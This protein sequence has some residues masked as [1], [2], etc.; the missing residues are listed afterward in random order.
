VACPSGRA[1]I[2]LPLG[3]GRICIEGLATAGDL[4]RGKRLMIPPTMHGHGAAPDRLS[5]IGDVDRKRASR[6]R[7]PMGRA[8]QR[9]DYT[10]QPP[11]TDPAPVENQVRRK[12]GR[13]EA[14]AQMMD[15]KGR[16][17]VRRG[18]ARRPPDSPRRIGQPSAK[19][20]PLEGQELW[21]PFDQDGVP[22]PRP[23]RTLPKSCASAAP[24]QRWRG[25]TLPLTPQR[26]ASGERGKL[27]RHAVGG[28]GGAPGASKIASPDRS[29]QRGAERGGRVGAYPLLSM[30]KRQAASR[31]DLVMICRMR[32]AIAIG[33][34]ACRTPAPQAVSIR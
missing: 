21:R 17:G 13:G 8:R 33:R 29:T 23:A 22:H 30:D 24:D 2:V 20:I 6:V 7:A 28:E 10:M 19:G 26:N 34:Y 3:V 1:D 12:L 5:P 4:S 32:L 25:R 14:G 27:P 15:E 18:S 16:Y 31:R 11:P 9:R